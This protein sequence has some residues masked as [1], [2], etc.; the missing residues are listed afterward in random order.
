MPPRGS[1]WTRCIGA[2]VP[3]LVVSALLAACGAPTEEPGAASSAVNDK[4]KDKKKI[5]ASIQGATLVVEGTKRPDVITLRLR[6]GDPSWLEVLDDGVASQGLSFTM[7]KFDHIVVSGNDGA[8]TIAIDESGGAF[9]TT[10]ITTLDGGDGNDTL[11]G[12]SGAE[13]LIGGDGDDL[14]H[15][16]RGDDIALLGAGNDTFTW[17]PGDGNDTIEGQAG[18]DT[19][20]FRAANIGENIDLSANGQR[21]RLFRD[22]A[23]ITMD[24]DGVE[25]IQLQTLGGADTITIGDLTGTAV[26]SVEVDLAAAGGGGDGQADRVVVLGTGGD[27]TVAV[28]GGPLGVEVTGLAATVAVT[29]GEPGLDT[30]S[31]QV[32]AGNDTVDASSV[33]AG[34]I[35]LELLGGPGD[36]LLI[37]GAGDDVIVGGQGLDVAL[38]GPGDD[39]FVWNPGDSSDVVEGQ[40]GT[41]RLEFRAANVSEHLDISANGQRL[42]LTRDVGNVVM[43]LAGVEVI[44]LQ[45]LGGADD[46]NVHD[47]SGTDAALVSVDLRAADGST[48]GQPDH[49]AFAATGGDDVVTI[50]GSPASGVTVTG[51]P[52]A[53]TIVGAEAGLDTISVDAGDGADTV[54]AGGLV[55][56][57]VILIGGAGN[58]V[59]HGGRAADVVIGGDGDDT[60]VWNPGDGS[61]TI[62]GQAGSDVLLFN[63]ANIAENVSIAPNGQR[64]LLTRD[65]AN[66]TL[67]IDGVEGIRLRM[68]GGADTIALGDMTGTALVAVE[69]NLAGPL[70]GGDG[71]ADTVHVY[72]TEGDDAIAVAGDPSS[73]VSVTGLAASCQITSP[74]PADALWIHGLGGTDS[75]NASG[76]APGTIG[77]FTDGV[78]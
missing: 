61:D 14:V 15:G 12:G 13:V 21:A 63:A 50:G 38:L 70:G 54:D 30:L 43:D 75:V 67:D 20:Q 5:V 19:L 45:L 25:D 11:I 77:L 57:A 59:L 53:T 9:T 16:G 44:S 22:V 31:I 8:D 71:S 69:V 72:G 24:L 74:E 7:D 27:D 68:L 3:G 76:L 32:L 48:D 60:F 35:G 42:R 39:T 34:A 37:G 26:T 56:I 40:G 62:E 6:P 33:A 28:A 58:D 29:S 10:K 66:V 2:S 1:R 23:S 4:D 36:D 55:G 41:D 52:Y 46:L 18:R 47:L 73:G 65:V 17:N 78:P 49:V 51:L 64:V